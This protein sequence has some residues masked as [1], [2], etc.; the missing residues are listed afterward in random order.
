MTPNPLV[1]TTLRKMFAA[2]ATPSRLIRYIADYHSSDPRWPQY[3]KNYFSSAFSIVL[4]D[5]E[6]QS[7]DAR[8]SEKKTSHLNTHVL[9]ELVGRAHLWQGISA[10]DRVWFDGLAVS[11]DELTLI[12]QIKPELHPSLSGSW[13]LMTQEARDFVRRA[14][15]NSQSYYEKTQIL[16]RL[17]EQLQQQLD[18]LERQPKTSRTA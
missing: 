8:L 3:V 15:V 7:P 6:N 10:S 2:G 13:L 11:P 18:D 14:M 16:A 9:H 17:V 4:L 5:M 12:D 1:V